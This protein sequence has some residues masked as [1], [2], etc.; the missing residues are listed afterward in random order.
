MKDENE[1]SMAFTIRLDGDVLKAFRKIQDET[2]IKRK[3]E[4]IRYIITM[5]SKHKENH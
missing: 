5:L 3:S 1:E 2:G 4:V